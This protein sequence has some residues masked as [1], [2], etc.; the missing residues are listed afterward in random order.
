MAQLDAARGIE[1]ALRHLERGEAVQALRVLD[2]VSWVDLGWP[3]YWRVRAEAFLLLGEA[4]R[5]AKCA[6]E[7]LQ[8]AP[9]NLELLAL[10]VRAL[11]HAQDYHKAQEVLNHALQLFP[12]SLELRQL[13][14]QCEIARTTPK[15]RTSPA[16]PHK[17]QGLER[18]PFSEAEARAIRRAF[19]T[20]AHKPKKRLRFWPWALLWLLGLGGYWFWVRNLG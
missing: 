10:Y 14:E 18:P 19:Q 2:K 20:P 1:L 12:P 17:D 3:D 15:A 16:A 6:E 7:G 5:A 11:L 4:R 8:E 9:D 13:A